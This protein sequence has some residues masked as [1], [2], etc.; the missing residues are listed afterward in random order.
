VVAGPDEA[1]SECA[2]PRA[3]ELAS[4]KSRNIFQLLAR[5]IWLP[6]EWLHFANA[7]I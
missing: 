7:E 6:P 5:L 4:F 3:Q 1:M 2:R